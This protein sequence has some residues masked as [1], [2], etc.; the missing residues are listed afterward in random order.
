MA[1]NNVKPHTQAVRTGAS[2][3]PFRMSQISTWGKV[4]LGAA[5]LA[6]LF[7][8]SLL[9]IHSPLETA[10]VTLLVGSIFFLARG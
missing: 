6:I 1:L 3:L 2:R 9:L 8:G 5:A 7:I 4:A 10:I